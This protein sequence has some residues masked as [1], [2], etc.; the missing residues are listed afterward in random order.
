MSNVQPVTT[1]ELEL[2]T[3]E[4]LPSRETLNCW[5]NHPTGSV[6]QINNGNIIG[7]Q[8]GLVNLNVAALNGNV[9]G[10]L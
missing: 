3:A 10:F 2:E 5:R 4:L 9:L 6:T 1:Q 7:S 8:A